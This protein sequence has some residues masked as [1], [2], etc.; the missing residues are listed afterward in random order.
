M[1]L[2][3]VQMLEKVQEQIENATPATAEYADDRFKT[4]LSASAGGDR[5]RPGRIV[6]L[7]PGGSRRPTTRI[8]T[9]E[10][11]IT[12]DLFL[13]YPAGEILKAVAD[14]E[15]IAETLHSLP[16]NVPDIAQVDIELGAIAPTG[17]NGIEV[18]RSLRIQ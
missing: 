5:R 7:V 3:A 15:A 1:P 2:S 13:Y 18:S 17:D 6:V 8:D 4:T 9:Q 16:G 12:L 14:A 11:E 10:H